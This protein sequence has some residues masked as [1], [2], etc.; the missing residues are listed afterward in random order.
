MCVCLSQQDLP[1]FNYGGLRWCGVDM[2]RVYNIGL[3]QVGP[4]GERIIDKK[5]KV[6]NRGQSKT[7]RVGRERCNP[8]TS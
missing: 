5:G 6:R 2:M 1:G 8:E 7:Y 3:Q 4:F